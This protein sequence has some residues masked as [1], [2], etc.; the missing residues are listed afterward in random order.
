MLVIINSETLYDKLT[1]FLIDGYLNKIR[2]CFLPPHC[3][4][5]RGF[6]FII[7]K[8]WFALRLRRS[9]LDWDADEGLGAGSQQFDL[10][11]GGGNPVQPLA[12]LLHHHV[13]AVRK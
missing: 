9:S 5:L 2:Y 10:L 6:L 4:L 7:L 11:G 12:V 13:P 1:Q 3:I 8:V